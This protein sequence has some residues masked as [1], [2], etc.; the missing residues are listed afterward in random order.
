[1][2]AVKTKVAVDVIKHDREGCVAYVVTDEATKQAFVVDPRLDQ[3]ETVQE[4]LRARGA[5][6]RWVVDTHTHADHLSGARRLA[7]REQAEL[8]AHAKAKLE[9]PAR[10]VQGGD[11]LRIGETEVR[12]LDAPGHTPDSLALH[13]DGHLFTGDALFVGGAGRTDFMGGSATDLFETFRR[14][15]ALP[16]DTVVHPGH[17]YVNRPESTI[18][19]EKRDNPLLAEHDQAKLVARLD[20]KGKPPANMPEILRFNLASDDSPTITPRDLDALLRSGAAPARLDVRGPLEFESE[21]LAGSKNVPLNELEARLAEVP[22]GEEVVVVCRTGVR[23]TIAAQTLRRHG[24]PARV[25]DG[26][27]V[28]WRRAGLTLKEGKKHLGLDRQ[29]QLIVGSTVLTTAILGAF[30]SPWF[31]ILTAFFGAGL[32]FAGATGTCGLAM[33]LMKAP[34]NRDAA[35]AGGG[36]VCA[37]SGGSTCAVGG[38]REPAAGASTCAVGGAK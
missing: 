38:A 7:R 18:G 26:G 14:L 12:V 1:M 9:A 24:R 32:T 16:E 19:A 21:H 8:L 15:E 10:R 29:V 31:L 17:D 27:V 28:G 23:A 5:T 37:A 13:V 33:V 3:V 22:E 11:V 25:L 35:S 2:I 34:W 20:V 6:L 36:A 30:V 4:R